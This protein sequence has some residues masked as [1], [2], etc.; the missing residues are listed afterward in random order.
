M[1][2][3]ALGQRKSCLERIRDSK[4]LF[5]YVVIFWLIH[6]GLFFV[7]EN[8]YPIEKHQVVHCWLDD[9][10]PFCEVFIVPYVGWFLLLLVTVLYFFFKDR[11]SLMSFH[12][13][14]LV[15]DVL[16]YGIYFIWP[17]QVDFQPEVMPRDNIFSDLVSLIYSADRNTNACPSFH[18]AYSFAVGTVWAKRKLTH[19]TKKTMVWIFVALICLATVFIKQHSVLDFFWALP[20][21]LL[22]EIVAYGK[23]YWLPKWKAKPAPQ[24]AE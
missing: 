21:C 24:N 6:L 7:T 14:L 3:S 16:M 23:S 13:Y 11:D 18:V 12:I 2:S 17:T 19:W 20:F 22:A 9:V 1:K 5:T 15:L 4:H 10:I 8:I